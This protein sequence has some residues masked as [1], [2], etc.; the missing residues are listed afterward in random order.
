MTLTVYRIGTRRARTLAELPYGSTLESGRWH[1]K[2]PDGP[3]V[4]YAGASRSI[5]QLEKRVHCNGIAPI[6]QIMLALELP[7]DAMLQTLDVGA[8]LPSDW[9]AQQALTQDLGVRWLRS[10]GALG[11][12]VPSAVEPDERNLLINPAHPAYLS[13]KIDVLRDPFAF[14]PRMFN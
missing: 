10:G 4:V 2:P 9:I 11:L 1:R 3:A 12:W 14:D 7:G 6:G 8:T 13:I 5:C